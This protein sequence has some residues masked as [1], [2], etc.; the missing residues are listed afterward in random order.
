MVGGFGGKRKNRSK[1]N[2]KFKINKNKG[3]LVCGF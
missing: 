3:R 1:A 2:R